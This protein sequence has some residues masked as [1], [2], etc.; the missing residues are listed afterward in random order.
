M[1]SGSG[2]LYGPQCT[3]Y[4]TMSRSRSDP[5]IMKVGTSDSPSDIS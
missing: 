2:P 4:S 5:T 3:V 1:T